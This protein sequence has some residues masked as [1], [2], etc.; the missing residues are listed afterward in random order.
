MGEGLSGGSWGGQISQWAPRFR[1]S[2]VVPVQPAA[3]N[4]GL[5]NETV[6]VLRKPRAT[7]KLAGLFSHSPL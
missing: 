5:V 6:Q 7:I 1:V 3:R 4:C 2:T